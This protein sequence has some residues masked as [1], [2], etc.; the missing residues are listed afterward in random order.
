MGIRSLLRIAFGRSATG[1][2]AEPDEPSVPQQN[3]GPAGPANTAPP[4]EPPA[5]EGVPATVS[6]PAQPTAE[7][8][9]RAA[10]PAVDRAGDTVPDPG[11]LGP[12]PGPPVPPPEPTPEPEPQPT[13]MPKPKPVPQP[14]PS[15]APDPQPL[16][17][18]PPGPEPRPRPA[19]PPPGPEPEPSPAM[20]PDLLTTAGACVRQQGLTGQRAA[21][22]LVLDRSGSMR[23]YYKDGSVQHLADQVL[24]LTA[25][26]ADGVLPVVFFSTDVDGTAA[27]TAGDH[28]DRVREL[29]ESYGHMGR[30][31]Y[32]RAIDAV[33]GH[34]KE[35]GT[36]DPALVVFQTDG[37]PSDRAAAEEALCAAAEF[38][39][40]WQFVGFGDPVSKTFGFL[41]RLSEQLPVPERRVVD[42][43]GFFHAGSE[44]R[45][46]PDGDLYRELLAGF[47]AWLDRARAAGIARP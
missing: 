17:E 33:V 31:H 7:T 16:P 32:H 43:A 29:H 25:H 45:L 38:P 3:A 10:D 42:N 18:P 39:L 46:L 41:R 6:V 36:T 13:P 37:A 28:E 11:P 27:L 23:P 19:E 34:Y 21:V 22:Y 24:A 4:P 30:T 26:L 9:D 15:P 44:P 5:A 20:D 35:S 2:S 1:T 14:E 8:A 40:Y 12:I 47:P